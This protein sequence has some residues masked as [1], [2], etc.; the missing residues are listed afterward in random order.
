MAMAF[1]KIAESAGISREQLVRLEAQTCA[2]SLRTALAL[3]EALDADL[4]TLFPRAG[5]ERELDP[6]LSSDKR[7]SP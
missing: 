6:A 2:P 4:L 1:G 5:K 7:T 3:A